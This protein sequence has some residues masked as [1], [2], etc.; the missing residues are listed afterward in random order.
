MDKIIIK[1]LLVRGIIGINEDERTNKQDILVNVVI[2]TDVRPAAGSDDIADAINYRTITKR[3]IQ[4]V[5]GSADFLVEK[6]VSDMARIII[7][8]FG[9]ERVMVRVEKPGA[10]RFARSVGVEIERAREDYR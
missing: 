9:A 5:E 6:L 3:I 10:L 4:H 8:E 1:D 2:Y 7:T